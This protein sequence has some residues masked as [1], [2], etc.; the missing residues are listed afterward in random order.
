MK[1]K[2]LK[3]LII[4]GLVVAILI[5]III[6][7]LTPKNKTVCYEYT[8]DDTDKN[9]TSETGSETDSLADDL[10]YSDFDEE[11]ELVCHYSDSSSYNSY[12]WHTTYISSGRTYTQG[13]EVSPSDTSKYDNVN[14]LEKVEDSNSVEKSGKST[15]ASEASKSSSKGSSSKSTSSRSSGKSSSAHSSGRSSGS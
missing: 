11:Q 6:D 13:N 1:N 4:I 15:S 10:G 9:T 12:Y 3:K 7:S 14:D 2:S 8:T 5:F